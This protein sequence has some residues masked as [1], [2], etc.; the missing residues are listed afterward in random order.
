MG[1]N[2]SDQLNSGVSD[3]YIINQLVSRA[4]K[5]VSISQLDQNTSYDFLNGQT[6]DQVLQ[7]LKDQKNC[8]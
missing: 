8:A 2:F 7:Q 1:M 6:P 4:I 5:A 3:K